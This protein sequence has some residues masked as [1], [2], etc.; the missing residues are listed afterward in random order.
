MNTTKVRVRND[1][2]RVSKR[3]AHRLRQAIARRRIQELREEKLLQGWL[4]EVWD[5]SPS[6]TES[7]SNLQLH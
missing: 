7:D 1:V 2:N 6:P 5:E 3:K 4:T